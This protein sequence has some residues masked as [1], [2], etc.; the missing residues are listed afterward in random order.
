MQGED[1]SE[2]K[3]KYT[4]SIQEHGRKARFFPPPLGWA[5]GWQPA[6]PCVRR[7][8]SG[9]RAHHIERRS[10][11]DARGCWLPPETGLG[12]SVLVVLGSARPGEAL[13]DGVFSGLCGVL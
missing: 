9:P 5:G 12:W 10:R 4:L 2:M 6:E 7:R 3:T 11:K 1:K 8:L 13:V